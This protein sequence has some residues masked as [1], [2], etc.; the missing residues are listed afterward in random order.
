MNHWSAGILPAPFWFMDALRESR[1]SVRQSVGQRRSETP[2]ASVP[3]FVVSRSELGCELTG[4]GPVRYSP[5]LDLDRSC[6]I[7]VRFLSMVL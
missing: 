7:G 3:L 1:Q 5:S 6:D 2:P 4:V